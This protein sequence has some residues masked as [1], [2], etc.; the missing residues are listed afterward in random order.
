[1]SDKSQSNNSTLD[2]S[3]PNFAGDDP[4]LHGYFI[5]PE[6]HVFYHGNIKEARIT[7]GLFLFFLEKKTSVC[8]ILV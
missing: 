1:M 6:A 5:T 8:E 7:N 2:F 4:R 3:A